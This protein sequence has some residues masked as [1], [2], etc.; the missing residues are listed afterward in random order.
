VKKDEK[1]EVISINEVSQDPK[2]APKTDKNEEN[3]DSG[4][5]KDEKKEVISTKEVSQDPQKV[6]KKDQNDE[7]NEKK[8]SPT[9]QKY[10]EVIILD[11]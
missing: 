1:K 7:D 5:K 11:D 2:E 3:S 6:P 10:P 8:V 4:V 9:Q